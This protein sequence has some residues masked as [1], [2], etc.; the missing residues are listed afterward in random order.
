MSELKRIDRLLRF[1]ASEEVW[2]SLDECAE[3]LEISPETA[4]EV[5]R[6]L[7]F[8]GFLEYNSKTRRVKIRHDLAEFIMG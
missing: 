6:L 7:A 2:R 5:V 8:V 4:G 1:L 3:V